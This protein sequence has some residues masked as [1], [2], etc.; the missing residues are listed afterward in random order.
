MV[1]VGLAVVF[2]MV[3]IS[4]VYSAARSAGD[5]FQVMSRKTNIQADV[6]SMMEEVIEDLKQA[7][8]V[9]I[10]RSDPY[11]DAVVYRLPV[12]VKIDGV[13]WGA[14]VF[15]ESNGKRLTRKGGW[16]RLF[17]TTVIEQKHKIKIKD[18][19]SKVARKIT[20]ALVRQSLD[21]NGRKIGDDEILG[22]CV[23]LIEDGK[24]RFSVTRNGRLVTIR[25]NF[26]SLVGTGNLESQAEQQR[27]PF[28]ATTSVHAANWDVDTSK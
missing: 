17:I 10:D 5:V 16:Q 15:N 22:T 25:I 19:A 4:G 21:H 23:D 24:K 9:T 14:F 2:L 20:R 27:K 1:E 26:P 13:Q 8:D 12:K 6:R 7:A 28:V 18:K 3:L 11:G